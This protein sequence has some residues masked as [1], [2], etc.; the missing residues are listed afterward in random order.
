MPTISLYNITNYLLE[1]P[2]HKEKNFE[3]YG[4]E[5]LLRYKT[6]RSYRLWKEDHINSLQYND[7]KPDLALVRCLSLA[8]YEKQGTEYRTFVVITKHTKKIVYGHC[9]CVAGLGEACTHVAGFLF[10][11]EE[12]VSEGLTELPDDLSC[13]EKL[14][15]WI[16][17][18]GP[19]DGPQLVQDIQF[20]KIY[21]GGKDNKHKAPIKDPRP[22]NDRQ[23]NRD[24]ALLLYHNLLEADSSDAPVVKILQAYF[25]NPS[26]PQL[27]STTST[28]DLNN[29][30]TPA[31]VMSYYSPSLVP[32]VVTEVN[33]EYTTLNVKDRVERILSDHPSANADTICNLLTVDQSFIDTVESLTLGQSQSLHWKNYRYNTCTASNSLAICTRITSFLDNKCNDGGS[34]LR[35]I[36]VSSTFGGNNATRYG[37]KHEALARKE[38]IDIMSKQRINFKCSESGFVYH[39]CGY[40]GASPDGICSC[41][42]H[43][44]KYLLEIKCPLSLE[45]KDPNQ[46]VKDIDFF[47]NNDSVNVVV[48]PSH[49]YY[50]QIITTMGVTKTELCKLVVWSPKGLL[51]VEVAKDSVKFQEILSKCKLY[52]KNFILPSLN[53]CIQS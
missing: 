48:K 22:T 15:K 37:T 9:H 52:F 34:V 10:A 31:I 43:K 19:K 13:T 2:P 1:S 35:L 51:I 42:C 4:K 32:C 16:V 46:F 36:D 12:F 26:L 44:E 50:F 3:S 38:F 53:N 25:D 41:D 29:Y 47:I 8:S 40:I 33:S 11:I 5:T 24:S 17:P 21:Y 7:F 49:K 20:S 27:T 30:E 6:L 39:P 18:K 45:N 14:C 23:I 28:S